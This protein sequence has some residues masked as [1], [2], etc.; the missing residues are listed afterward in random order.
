MCTLILAHQV[1]DHTPVFLASNRDEHLDRPAAGPQLWDQYGTRFVAPRD[2][3]EGGTWLG[4]NEW[5]VL[6]A[7]TNRFGN[8]RDGSRRSRGRLVLEALKERYAKVAAD[9]IYAL[10]PAEYNPFHLLIVDRG[11]AHVVWGDG[12]SMHRDALDAGVHVVTER[13]YLAAPNGRAEFLTQRI[14]ELRQ[15]SE[16]RE[17]ELTRLLAISRVDDIDATCVLIPELNYGT[18]SSTIVALGSEPRLEYAD[19]PPCEAGYDDYTA[20]LRDVLR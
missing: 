3:R 16:L 17:S 15:A 8:P 1:F 5:G 19:G 11:S 7:I 6:V 18:R 9:G 2:E 10:D 20:L 13:S 4:V 14:E 12:Q